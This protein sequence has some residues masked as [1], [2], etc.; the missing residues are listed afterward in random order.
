VNVAVQADQRA[1]ERAQQEFHEPLLFE[2]GA[3]TGKTG[4][5]VARIVVWCLGPGWE[6]NAARLAEPG[7]ALL[8]ERIASE[9]LRRVVAITFT[10]AAAAEMATRVSA[11]LRAIE[12]GE[13]PVSVDAQALPA[14]LELRRA[15]AR[16]LLGALDQLGVRTIHAFCR[17]LLAAHPLEAGLHPRFEVDADGQIQAE[18]AREVLEASLPEAWG[19]PPDTRHQTLASAGLGPADLETALVA[20]L[21]EGVV[22]EELSD[23][24]RPESLRAFVGSLQERFDAFLGC[25]AGRLAALSGRAR[26]VAESAARVAGLH[27]SLIRVS[28]AEPASLEEF[29]DELREELPGLQYH[30]KK[31]E[32]GDFGKQGGADLGDDAPA[33][34]TAAGE[35]RRS[36]APLPRMDLAAL[37]AGFRVL[38][39]LLV[40]ARARLRARGVESFGGLLRGAR[41]LLRA[42]PDVAE[43][44]RRV[45]DQLLVDEFQDT[46]AMQC[47]LLE[48]LALQGQTR[49]GLFLV[50]DPKQSIYGW[51]NADLGAYDGFKKCLAAAGGEVQR[52][53]VN[54]RSAPAI[55]EEVTRML[56]PV[57]QEATGLQ[58]RFERLL[59]SEQTREGT[60]FQAGELAPVEHWLSVG[61]DG[62]GALERRTRSRRAAEIEAEALAQDLLRLRDEHDVALGKVALLFRSTGDLDIYL[63][64]LRSAGIPFLATREAQ[65]YQ[66]RE[67]IDVLGLVRCILD[68]HDHLALVTTLRGALVGVPDAA[69][70]PL[71][72]HGLPA[73]V[74]ALRGED[75]ELRRRLRACVAAAEKELPAGIPGLARLAGF[76]IALEAFLDALAE[77]RARLA[78]DSAEALVEALRS[79]LL[80]EVSEAARS[81]GAYR[82]ANLERFFRDLV[83]ALEDHGGSSA[84]VAAFLR[85]A[86]S[87]AREH[88][89]GRSRPISDD[90]VQVMTIHHAKGLDFDHVYLLQTHKRGGRGGRQP[91][92]RVDRRGGR[93]ELQLMGIPTPG[94]Q[95]SAHEREAA[96]ACERVRLLYVASTR[97]RERLVV[98]GKWTVR[99]GPEPLQAA[100]LAEL[101]SRRA[102]TADDLLGRLEASARAGLSS[103]QD[104]QGVR[105]VLPVKTPAAAEPAQRQGDRAASLS[106]VRADRDRLAADRV[107]AARRMA[108]L[109]ASVAS[110]HEESAPEPRDVGDDAV[111]GS[112]SAEPDPERR[113]AMAAGTALHAVLEALD[114]EAPVEGWQAVPGIER[115]LAAA[116]GPGERDRARRRAEALWQA[117]CAGPLAKRLRA[118][119]PQ[120]VARELPVLLAPGLFPGNA[121]QAP[122][123]YVAGAIDLL[124][125]DPADGAFVVVDYKTDRVPAGADLGSHSER[126]RGQGT[127]Y[128]RALQRALGLPAEPRFELWYL[129]QGEVWSASRASRIPAPHGRML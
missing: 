55:L 27:A 34:A 74:G 123:G 24:L 96:Q 56:A 104:A 9:T 6:H 62:A 11:A 1:R 127:V 7:R 65:Y 40:E 21:G 108:R 46:D 86:A 119:A 107:V 71:W 76:P 89:E 99:P 57:M 93:L 49:P 51:R 60:G 48:A 101:L 98:A 25:E 102:E 8:D 19:E 115:A 112:L 10:E 66:R 114:L 31:W 124:Y 16:L 15:R 83:Q 2:A 109:S 68:P 126:Y 36:L 111:P 43:R 47:E 29:L 122:V 94:F 120:I 20:L 85:R 53:V 116:L 88:R 77:L 5:L 90:A 38:R 78:T 113:V 73:L 52:L 30:L 81:L 54:F 97:A 42:R 75:P 95:A 105:W 92:T 125:R 26:N 22:P 28:P 84:A 41:D 13:L 39:D 69:L 14:D 121:E 70:L 45:I 61:L 3:G 18:V 67:M 80:P 100:S 33:V 59:P 58:P 103:F 82:L 50:G 35:L 44:E 63:G 117:F 79:R 23:P 37:D 128:T 72:R 64:A 106:Q 17:R 129:A 110:H 91:E 4:V 87:D 12:E 118:L 32:K